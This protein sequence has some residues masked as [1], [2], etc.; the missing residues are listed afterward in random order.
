VEI[1]T[2]DHT[3]PE[4]IE[5]IDI[6]GV[7]LIRAAAKNYTNVIVV[8]DPS[9]YRWIAD[10]LGSGKLLSRK[11]RLNLARKAFNYTARYDTAIARYFQSIEEKPTNNL[12]I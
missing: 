6:G 12:D 4:A 3:L 10:S 8:T 5:S 1:T 9:D 11:E 7:T 2:Q